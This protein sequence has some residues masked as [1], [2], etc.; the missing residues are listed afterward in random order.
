MNALEQR[1][2]VLL[3]RIDSHRTVILREFEILKGA[4]PLNPLFTGI[5]FIRRS[6]RD[7]RSVAAVAL[8]VLKVILEGR[9]APGG[10][11]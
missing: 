9:G 4:N 5:A 8:R 6:L 1:K 7:V 2:Q 3:E 11:P 10:T